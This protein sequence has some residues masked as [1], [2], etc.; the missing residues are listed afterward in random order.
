MHHVVVREN[1]TPSIIPRIKSP[2]VQHIDIPFQRLG[3]HKACVAA[4]KYI[5]CVLAVT[6]NADLFVGIPNGVIGG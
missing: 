6:A 4:L 5:A 3:D 2:L 1:R